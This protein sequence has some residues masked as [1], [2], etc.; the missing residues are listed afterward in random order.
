MKILIIDNNI[1][2]DS[3]GSSDLCRLTRGFP[4]ATVYV[5]NGPESDLPPHP[6]QY[7]KI[8]VSGS[9]TSAMSEEPWI[10]ELTDFIR[11]AIDLRKP[12]LGVCYGHQMLARA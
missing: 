7:D 5:R 12:Y 10:E 11:K 9:K 1:D 4:G 2:R 8:I 6:A 3:W